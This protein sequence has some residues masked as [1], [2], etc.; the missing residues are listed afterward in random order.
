M[1]KDCRHLGRNQLQEPRGGDHRTP[2]QVRQDRKR[3][4]EEASRF[5]RC[6]HLGKR[7]DW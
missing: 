5:E 7:M 4:A 3:E 1:L 6:K 2:D